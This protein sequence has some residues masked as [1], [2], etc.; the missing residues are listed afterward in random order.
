MDLIYLKK[1]ICEFICG[2]EAGY[3]PP[4]KDSPDSQHHGHFEKCVKCRLKP[5]LIA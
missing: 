2:S 4:E 1:Q 5:I 3:Y